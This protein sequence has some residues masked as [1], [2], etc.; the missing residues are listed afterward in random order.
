MLDTQMRDGMTIMPSWEQPK[1]SGFGSSVLAIMLAAVI[2]AALAFGGTFL[3]FHPET[4]DLKADLA[5][6]EATSEQLHQQN[7]S[8]QVKLTSVQTQLG[9]TQKHLVK[10]EREL[11]STKK[12]LKATGQDLVTAKANATSAYSNGY[13]TGATAGSAQAADSSWNAGYNA[14]YNAGF[15]DGWYGY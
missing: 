14:G 3:Y 7:D 13:S 12:K 11:R 10:T 1:G 5:K 6:A 9:S 8:T 4:T 2:G 15:N